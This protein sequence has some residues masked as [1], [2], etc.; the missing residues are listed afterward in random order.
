METYTE[1]AQ[2]LDLADKNA[3][4]TIFDMIKNLKENMTLISEETVN[5]GR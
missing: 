2:V 3:K 1:M 4:A 5:L